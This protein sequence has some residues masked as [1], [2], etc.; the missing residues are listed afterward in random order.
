MIGTR[1]HPN[2]DGFLSREEIDKPGA[3]G[4]CTVYDE[5]L[6]NSGLTFWECTAP[7]GDRCSLDPKI[8]ALT[9]EEDGTLTVSPSI[10]FP[11]KDGKMNGWHGY[12]K[13][14]VWSS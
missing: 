2:S 8:H 12:L 6:P 10:Q 3:Y 9:I 1:V 7:N 14:G 5:R 11:G 13:R 4:R